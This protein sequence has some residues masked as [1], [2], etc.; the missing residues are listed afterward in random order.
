V[1]RVGNSIVSRIYYLLYRNVIFRDFIYV[2]TLSFWVE[3]RIYLES[4]Q[5]YGAGKDTWL[6]E[7]GINMGVLK[8]CSVRSVKICTHPE[9]SHWLWDQW[10]MSWGKT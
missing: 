2:L 6:L 1:V 5:E 4:F 3:G 9:T 7:K 10:G 8:S